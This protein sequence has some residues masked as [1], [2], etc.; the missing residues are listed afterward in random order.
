MIY[1]SIA[2]KI[3]V[4]FPYPL[5]IP[6]GVLGIFYV[7]VTPNMPPVPWITNGALLGGRLARFLMKLLEKM[8]VKLRPEIKTKHG[9]Q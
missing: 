6:G 1:T 9:A 3:A 2:S 4:V 5:P 8:A 7:N